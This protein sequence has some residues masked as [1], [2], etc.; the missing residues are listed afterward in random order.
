MTFPASAYRNVWGARGS[1]DAPQ[2]LNLWEEGRTLHPIDRA[3]TLLTAAFPG[4]A[5][6]TLAALPIGE[7]DAALLELR[8]DLFGN[9]LEGDSQCSSC[10]RQVEFQADIAELL[11]SANRDLYSGNRGGTLRLPEGR[12]LEFRLPDSVDLSLLVGADSPEGARRLLAE[13]CLA[14]GGEGSDAGGG[15][16]PLTDEVIAALS[17][18]MEECDPL[19]DIQ[20]DLACPDCGSRWSVTLDIL[21][22]LWE[23][24]AR[25]AHRL[26]RDVHVL[27]RA[28]GWS[29]QSILGLSPARRKTY[30]EMIL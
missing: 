12:S 25:E 17:V 23:E 29:E 28:Y 9:Q 13:R 11:A 14:M 3:L 1:L 16:E 27:A 4:V 19:A 20:F 21:S 7:R 8:R 15:A 22:W 10:G 30:I 24:L 6:E 2:I 18:A 5:W 26:L